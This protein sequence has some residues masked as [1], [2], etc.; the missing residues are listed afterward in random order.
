MNKF[1]TGRVQMF[2]AGICSLFIMMLFS[3][4]QGFAI[5]GTNG[6]TEKATLTGQVQSVNTSAHSTTLNV[7]GQQVT[8]NGLTDQQI[9]LLQSQQGKTFTIQVIQAG[10]NTYIISDN[11]QPQENNN[12]THGVINNMP[13]NNNNGVNEPGTIEFVGKVQAVNNSSITVGMPDG[14]GLLM[15]N[16]NGQTDEEDLN[17]AQLSVGQLVKVNATANTIDGSFIASKLG[18]A[19]PDDV[20]NQNIVKYQGVTT[21]AVSTDNNLS[22]K[23]GNKSFKF[24][25]GTGADLDD[26][27]YNAQNIGNTIPVKVKVV[28]SGATGTVLSVG[29]ANN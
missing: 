9:A 24:V 15:N 11:T 21:S 12:A 23:L 14:Q 20:Q 7:N 6:T 5:P 28:F 3:A 18:L 4:C 27:N 19:K 8:V 17:G 2:I 16:V 22:F 10:I 29:R 1:L 25:I 26:F 13:E